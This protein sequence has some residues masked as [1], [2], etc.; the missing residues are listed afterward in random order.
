MSMSDHTDLR[1]TNIAGVRILEFSGHRTEA[2][3]SHRARRWRKPSADAA[4][5]RTW[6]LCRVC[7]FGRCLDG[8]CGVAGTTDLGNSLDRHLL[9]CWSVSACLWGKPGTR[10]VQAARRRHGPD[11]HGVDQWFPIKFGPEWIDIVGFS[12]AELTTTIVGPSWSVSAM[13]TSGW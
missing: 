4:P 10:I 6:K 1:R 8:A 9:V 3:G 2:Q 7:P 11:I 5:A 12:L 13:H